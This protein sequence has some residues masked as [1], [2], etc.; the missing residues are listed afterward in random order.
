MKTNYLKSKHEAG[1]SFEDYLNHAKPSE[2]ENWLKTYDSISLSDQQRQLLGSFSREMKVVVLSGSWCGD[3]SQQGPIL[4]RIAET[5]PQKINL[6]W[7]ERDDHMDLSD[8][9]MINGG[10]RV[11]IVVFC[12]ED[13]EQVG[14]FGDRVLSR[15]RAMAAQNLGGACPLPGAP[16][17][18]D[19]IKGAISDWVQ[20]FERVHLL[21]RLSGRLRQKHGD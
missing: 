2:K 10:N 16:V 13:Y 17:P 6:R 3:C 5:N 11:P 8:Q 15:Y 7:L 9:L 18:D 21:L 12:A 14:W 19:Q 1:L 4:Q 20:Q